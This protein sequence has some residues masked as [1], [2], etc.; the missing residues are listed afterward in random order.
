VN[1]SYEEFYGNKIENTSIE[2]AEYFN[3]IEEYIKNKDNR[4]NYIMKK[5]FGL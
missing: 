3:F 1:L 2:R 5:Y 4:I